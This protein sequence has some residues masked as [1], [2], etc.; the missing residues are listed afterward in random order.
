[1][2]TAALP[3]YGT[4][5]KRG[6]S[7][8][9]SSPNAYATIGEVKSIKGPSTK[10]SVIDVTTHSSAASGNYREKIPSLIDPGEITF[11]LNYVPTDATLVLLR[12]DLTNRTKR[13]FQVLPAGTAQIISFS[14]Y[15][16]DFPLEF[17]T[18]DVM[19]ASITITVTGAIT[20]A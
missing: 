19:S 20:F 15:V 1:M 9:G 4:L 16:T 10:V 8:S 12:A 6:S 14:G 7:P 17:P 18:D 5:I 11:D 2:P 13:D 3:A